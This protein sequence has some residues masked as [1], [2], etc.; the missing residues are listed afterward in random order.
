MLTIKQLGIN[1]CTAFYI[2]R[3]AIGFSYFRLPVLQHCAHPGNNRTPLSTYFI[4]RL[5]PQAH[6][7]SS[8]FLRSLLSPAHTQEELPFRKTVNE[9]KKKS[10]KN[11]IKTQ[12]L[13]I[14]FYTLHMYKWISVFVYA[15]ANFSFYRFESHTIH[16]ITCL[17]HLTSMNLFQAWLFLDKSAYN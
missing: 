17:F 9:K 2:F 3:E 13:P 10:I 16:N 15:Y 6:L 12:F 14:I 11:E 5:Q 7:R 4:G 1:K 8:I